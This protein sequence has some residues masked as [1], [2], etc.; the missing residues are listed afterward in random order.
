MI[1]TTHLLLVALGGMLG[2][3][4]RYVV[5]V[6]INSRTAT[7]TVIPWG[8]FG[9]NII[10]SLIIGLVFGYSMRNPGFE[11]NWRVFLATGVCGGFTTFSALSNESYLLLKEQ[12]YA[13]LLL[14][15]AAS[16]VLGIGA[17]A[18][19]YWVAK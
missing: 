5:S 7:V 12:Q 17:T 15:I 13:P 16:L 1:N 9:V 14:Y 2:S 11:Q 18:L 6:L 4:L 3:A 8:T 19:G 10:G